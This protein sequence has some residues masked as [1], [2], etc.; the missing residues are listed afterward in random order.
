MYEDSTSLG[1]ALGEISILLLTIVMLGTR[2]PLPV[3]LFAAE[4]NIVHVR[5]V[6]LR[7]N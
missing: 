1:K 5:L 2:S 7:P 6:K 3:K 4:G